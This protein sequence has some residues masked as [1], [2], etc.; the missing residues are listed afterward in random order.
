MIQSNV[1]EKAMH[2]CPEHGRPNQMVQSQPVQLL[3]RD[4]LEV[5]VHCGCG[6]FFQL[7]RQAFQERAPGRGGTQCRDEVRLYLGCF[8]GH[9][10]QS[11]AIP[12]ANVVQI[13]YL[14]FYG[15]ERFSSVFVPN[16]NCKFIGADYVP[17]ARGAAPAVMELQ[18]DNGVPVLVILDDHRSGRSQVVHQHLSIGRSRGHLQSGLVEPNGSETHPTSIGRCSH[19]QG[20]DG[21]PLAQIEALQNPV[22]S[23]TGKHPM[24]G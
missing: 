20:P 16:P 11:L 23:C 9:Q 10:D 4:E 15:G 24:H 3:F 2:V 18:V 19:I 5:L 1:H 6:V 12:D 13:G 7:F 22:F 14:R 17:F 8:G 21:H